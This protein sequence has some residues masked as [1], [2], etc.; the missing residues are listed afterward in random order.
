MEELELEHCV[1]VTTM[2]YLFKNY[3]LLNSNN[4][5]SFILA[6]ICHVLKTTGLFR[7]LGY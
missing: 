6:R 2:N 7:I 5:V 1:V 4:Y 3:V